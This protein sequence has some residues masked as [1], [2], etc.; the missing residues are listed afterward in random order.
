M[1]GSTFLIKRV[2]DD[3]DISDGHRVLVDRLWPR[4]LTKEAAALDEWCKGVAPSN[5]LRKWVHEDPGPADDARWAEFER[6]Y[7]EELDG[8]ED[9]WRPLLERAGEG[10]VTLLY[11]AR[12]TERNHALVLKAYLESRP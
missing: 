10:P 1:S 12:D 9:A 2:Y 5:D 8:A 6:M 7:A 11:A 4:G 3:P